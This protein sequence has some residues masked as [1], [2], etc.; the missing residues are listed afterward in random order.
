MRAGELTRRL[1]FR[2]APLVDDGLQAAI[3]AFADLGSPVW[4]ARS[5]MSD[6]EKL[7]SGQS[8]GTL[9]SRFRIRAST[10]SRGVTVKDRFSCDGKDWAILGIKE[11]EGRVALE[12]TALAR[13][14]Q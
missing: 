2:R 1:Q 8:L 3:G 14:D 9:I 11:S 6:G 4:G 13:V 10:F 7:T 12:L 5:D